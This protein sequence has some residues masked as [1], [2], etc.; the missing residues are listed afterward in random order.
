MNIN[1]NIERYFKSFVDQE[2]PFDFFKGLA[3]Y[4]DYVFSVPVLK[5]EFDKQLAERRVLYK[6]I[7]DAEKRTREELGQTKAK[8][9]TL[10][11]KTGLDIK[12]FVRYQTRAFNENA[13]IIEEM[14]AY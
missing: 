7:E 1:Q 6:E 5:K 3:T 12:S 13:D 14:D 4:L 8:L 11:K 9:L 2:R 10:I